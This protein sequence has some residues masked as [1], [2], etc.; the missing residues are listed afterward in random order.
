MNRKKRILF[1]TEFSMLYSGYSTYSLDCL[2]YLY[3]TGKYELFELAA[4][5]EPGNQLINKVPW[6]VI[7]NLPTPGNEEETRIYESDNYN[8]FG[9]W[10]FEQSLISSQADIVFDVRDIWFCNYSIHNPLRRFYNL[11]LMPACDAEPQAP[12]WINSYCNVEGIATYSNW[13]KDLLDSQCKNN[14]NFIGRAS[15]AS[16]PET[17]KPL[18]DKRKVKEYLGINPEHKIIGMVARN[19]DRK[20]FP[21][22]MNT[23]LLFL[24]KSPENLKNSTY[25]YL[26]T[27]H[28]DVGW[29]IPKLLLDYGLGN[30]VYFTYRCLNKSCGYIHSSLFKESIGFCPK[31]KLRSCSTPKSA[32]GIT[33]DE[34]N[35]V[36]NAFDVYVQ[37]AKNEGFAIPI[38]EAATAGIPTIVTDYSA[39][40]DFKHTLNSI[41][42]KYIST[43]RECSSGRYTVL[44]NPYHTSNELIKILSL[45]FNIRSRIGWE[46]RQL[47][48]KNYNKQEMF[49][50]WE[51]A[52]D[53]ASYKD[54][55]SPPK[56]INPNTNFNPPNNAYD[57]VRTC[58]ENIIQLPFL[59]D[60]YMMFRA[61][62][63]ID[64]GYTE[65]RGSLFYHDEKTLVNRPN[66]FRQY[67]PDDFIKDCLR[68]VENYNNWE[69]KRVD[70]LKV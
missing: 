57:F 65:Q 61:I 49:K 52:F 58:L 26:H 21:A 64:R 41:P 31:C 62:R 54:W 10:K 43:D 5:C 40:E 20:L 27:A 66:D 63:D 25:L 35:I 69:K 42:I 36:Y 13:A 50:V 11:F 30:K 45:P 29:D 12:D 53:N 9:K 68:I 51:N 37:Y 16:N 39:M 33:S 48:I 17:F 15:P 60:T 47:A 22:L 8:T 34:L 4:Y 38:L 55:K 24:Q 19:Q 44:P 14:Y 70:F 1:N 23:F 59:F 56:F 28:P 7:P 2:N 6:K 46:S 3:N 67:K 18:G 32:D